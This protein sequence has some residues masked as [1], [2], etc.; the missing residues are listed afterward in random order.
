MPPPGPG[1]RRGAPR[2]A[3]LRRQQLAAQRSRLPAVRA[4]CTMSAGCPIYRPRDDAPRPRAH[5]C[6]L[7]LP[8]V[9]RGFFGCTDCIE[10]FGER[11]IAGGTVTPC[12]EHLPKSG[13][14]SFA[15]DRHDPRYGSSVPLDDERVSAIT[16]LGQDLSEIAGEVGGSNRTF[17]NS[18]STGLWAPWAAV[19][20]GTRPRRQSA[21]SGHWTVSRIRIVSFAIESASL[22]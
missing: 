1:Y 11:V 5:L 2:R 20:L 17:H 6:R 3:V 10:V 14:I 15:F 12:A 16:H 18:E 9:H 8:S 4:D 13:V 19:P 7:R 21:R 22:R